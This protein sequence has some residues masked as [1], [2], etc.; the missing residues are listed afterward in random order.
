MPTLQ[1]FNS[2]RVDLGKGV[3]DLET[4]TLKWIL[5]NTAPS[6][7]NTVAA[8]ITEI[9]AGNGYTAGG[10]ALTGQDFVEDSGV[11]RLVADDTVWTASG[12]SIGPFRYA[13]LNNVT[14]GRLVGWYDHGSSIT[15]TDTNTYTA[16][17]DPA[18]GI[19]TVA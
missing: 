4:D 12:G 14:A 2:F 5:T 8:D 13:V 19:L 16:D 10:Q 11:A 7:A 6:A 1:K 3:H 17:V 15:V 18:L 9:D